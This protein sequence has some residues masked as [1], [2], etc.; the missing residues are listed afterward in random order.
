MDSR[1]TEASHDLRMRRWRCRMD[2]LLI[3]GGMKVADFSFL[4]RSSFQR[5]GSFG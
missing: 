4:G 3:I 1:G 2:G 5:S